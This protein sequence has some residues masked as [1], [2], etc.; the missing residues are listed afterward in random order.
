MIAFSLAG[1]KTVGV[2][3]VGLNFLPRSEW[4]TLHVAIVSPSVLR[5]GFFYWPPDQLN[6]RRK[7]VK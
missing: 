3:L 4:V 7:E 2:H 1:L 6:F 5:R